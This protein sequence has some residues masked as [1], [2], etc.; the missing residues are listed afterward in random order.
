MGTLVVVRHGQASFGKADYDQL[1]ELGTAQGQMLGQWWA[2]RGMRFDAVYTG[3][4]KRHWQTCE[5]AREAMASAG[6]P[7]PEPV[8]IDG[9]AEYDASA[10]FTKGLPYV[11]ERRPELAAELERYRAGGPDKADGFQRVLEALGRAWARGEFET[12]GLESWRGFRQRVDAGI[13]EVLERAERGQ[14]A[15][16]FTSGGPLGVAVGRALA[17]GDERTLE[18]SWEVVN[19]A[20]ARF[21]FSSSGRFTLSAFNTTDHLIDR[22]SVTYR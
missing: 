14:K 3:P 19:A 20:T 1:S 6:S 15:V 12:E 7:L 2:A 11:L 5:A 21:K 4:M 13:D 10:L 22:A 16:V 8:E 9:F 18:L 17:L